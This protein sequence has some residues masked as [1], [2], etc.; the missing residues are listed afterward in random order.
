MTG[1]Y[2][3]SLLL[4][5][6]SAVDRLANRMA[7]GFRGDRARTESGQ[8]LTIL[9]GMIVV[10]AVVWIL[11]SWTDRRRRVAAY[12][13]PRRLFWSLA[14]A[15]R[16]A[17]RDAWL[18]WRLARWHGLAAPARVFLNP[19]WFEVEGLSRSLE[20]REA[21]L[22]SLRKRL[23]SGLPQP[24]PAPASPTGPSSVGL[25]VAVPA[26]GPLLSGLAQSPPG[27]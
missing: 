12:R 7:D 26:L 4:A 14:K 8:L 10:V 15:H 22:E 2:Q 24:Q 25:P 1:W 21:R 5:D 16:L 11:S 27:P 13:S 20:R 9:I 17:W 19:E 3:A 23:F 6:R 18:L